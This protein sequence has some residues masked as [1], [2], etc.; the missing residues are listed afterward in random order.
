MKTK[1]ELNT[2][3]EEV[4]NLRK[5][6]AELS[7]DELKQVVGGASG[8]VDSLRGTQECDEFLAVIR[9]AMGKNFPEQDKSLLQTYKKDI[10]SDKN[11]K[12]KFL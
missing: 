7:E 8:C 9:P 12:V 10:G 1:E 6:L 5:K 4:E 11:A 2:L 3:K